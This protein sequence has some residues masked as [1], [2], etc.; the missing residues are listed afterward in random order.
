MVIDLHLQ[1]RCFSPLILNFKWFH[2]SAPTL[3]IVLVIQA[4]A[5]HCPVI[6]KEVDELLA[7]GATE[8]STGGSDLY[9][10]VPVAPKCA[11][12]L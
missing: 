3:P 11:G 2:I 6:Q 4:A 5:A 7:K 9:S 8:P 10:N 1:L 12:G